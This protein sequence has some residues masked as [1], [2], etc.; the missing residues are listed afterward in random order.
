MVSDEIKEPKVD[1]ENNH[2]REEI[3]FQYFWYLFIFFTIYLTS[4]IV[5]AFLFMSYV[6]LFFL[7]NFLNT[8]SF[9]A[10]FT[11][12]KPILALVSMPLVIIGCYLVR[13]FFIGLTTRFFWRLSE[14]K[15]PSKDG[16]IPRNFP[17]KT[18]NYYH[19]RSFLI[20][21]GKNTFT[22]GAFP[23]LS[24]WL[25]NFV[26]SSVIGKGSTLEESIGNE[27][28]GIVGKNCYFGAGSA[29]ATHLVD[30]TFGNIN[31]FH[32]KI[33]DNVTAAATNLVAAGSEV[34]DNSYLLPLASAGKH[35]VLKG[36][37]YYWGIPLRKIFRKKTMEY[38]GLTAKE[39]EI[40]A[41]I[42]GYNDKKV[43]EKLKSEKILGSLK[44]IIHPEQEESPDSDKIMDIN[45]LSEEDLALDFTT[46]SA[47]S[48]VNIKFLIVYIPIF[49]LSGMLDTIIFY[50]FISLV[51]NV[52]VMVFFLP[53]M[54]IIMWFV[55]ILGCFF[56]S[57]LFLILINLIHKPNEGVFRAEIGDPDFEFWSLRTEIKKIVLWL[58]RN[59]PLPWAD[60]LAFKFFGVKMTLSSSLYD[61]WCDGEFITFGRNVLVG[62]GVTIMSSMVVG[63]YLIIK[64]VICGDYSLIGGH[65]TVAPGTIIG[66]DTFVSALSTSVFS[67]ILEPGWIY[68]GIPCIKLKPNKYAESQREILMKRD[69]DGEK[70]FE[71]E[72]EVNIDEDKKD[73]V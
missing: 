45:D 23:W 59:W 42:A 25:F 58:L 16:I 24:N 22:K 47:I 33:G 44:E 62:Q 21:Y 10:L 2:I 50:T 67:Q 36:N 57:K 68:I 65:S 15:S 52:F 69:V 20:K 46:S 27:K 53:T 17:S 66:E 60:I 71:I 55:F 9:I 38:L 64:N 29:L 8:P 73:L 5:P 70:K 18:L 41:N 4:Y 39:L 63:K 32:V 6:F 31:Y 54:I 30:G 11:E 34:H 49:W 7:P 48:R 13:L 3:K 28:F 26:G 40:N 1:T 43:I 12:L 14:K 37:N 56:F 19:I 51:K 61:S 35:S 72:H